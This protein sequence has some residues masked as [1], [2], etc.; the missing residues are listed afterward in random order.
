[1][2]PLETAEPADRMSTWYTT[3]T[4]GVDWTWHGVALAPRPGTWDAR[5]VQPGAVSVRDG[6]G[7]PL[8]RGHPRGRC[9]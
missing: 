5:G 2:H 8:L 1:M 9:P 6:A 7:P 3:S 4:D